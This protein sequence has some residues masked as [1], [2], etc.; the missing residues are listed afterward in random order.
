[1]I[2]WLNEA[3]ACDTRMARAPAFYCEQKFCRVAFQLSQP[4][5]LT[6]STLPS[7]P[8]RA[9]NILHSLIGVVLESFALLRALRIEAL[10]EP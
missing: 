8:F 2:G 7:F 1:M 10:F 3:T 9:I 6:S 4:H 5:F